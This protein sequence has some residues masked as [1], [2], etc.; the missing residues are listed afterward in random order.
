MNDYQATKQEYPELVNIWSKSV[1][2]THD[3]LKPSDFEQIK[4]ELPTYFS[5]VDVHIWMDQ[6]KIIGFSGVAEKKLEMLFLD[7]EF[8]GKG[9]GKRIL[10]DLIAKSN[11]EYVDVNEQNKAASDFY[12]AMGFS[13]YARSDQD[14]AGRAY[15]ILH[16]KK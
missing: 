10:A 3:F 5:Q 13:I 1:K 4:Q 9:Y 11:I 7:P 16:L 8:I 15:P 12:Q 14:E 2:A 6:G